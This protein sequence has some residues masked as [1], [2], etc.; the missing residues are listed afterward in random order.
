VNPVTAKRRQ[1][2][3]RRATSAPAHEATSAPGL[4]ATSAP[5]LETTSRQGSAAHDDVGDGSFADAD[6]GGAA[7][8]IPGGPATSGGPEGATAVT[9]EEATAA[10]EEDTVAAGDAPAAAADGAA[11][12]RNQATDVQDYAERTVNYWCSEQ[13]G[14]D[15]VPKL[16]TIRLRRAAH[17]LERELRRELAAQ[18]M[19]LW[20]FEVLFSLRRAPEYRKSAGALLRESQVTSGAITNRIGRLESRGWVRR[21][22]DHNDRR[23]VLVSLTDEGMARA[24]Q[25]VTTKTKAEAR[26]LAGLDRQAQ[27]RLAA[28]LRTLLLALE[29]PADPT[30]DPDCAGASTLIPSSGSPPDVAVN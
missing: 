11:E 10:D 28:D 3:D 14:L 22:V 30:T 18:E 27:E 21:D 6:G 23:Q 24:E 8:G 12:A 2:S 7:A 13:P 29:G 16:L 20:E 1:P 17:Y 5:G 26:V 19:E 15:P 25:L 4:E 9:E